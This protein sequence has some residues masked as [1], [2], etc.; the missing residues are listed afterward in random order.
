G[1]RA[2]V[3]K[4]MDQLEAHPCT[5]TAQHQEHQSEIC[6]VIEHEELQA[7]RDIGDE[8]FILLADI[9]EQ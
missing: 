2:I 8:I 7:L 6:I 5:C 3:E 4:L 1:S 9:V